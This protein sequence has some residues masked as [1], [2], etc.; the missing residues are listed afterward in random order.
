MTISDSLQAVH[1]EIEQGIGLTK[2]QKC[3]CMREALGNLAALLYEV[4]AEE[5]KA[6]R[7]SI[8]TWKEQ[9]KPV[10]YACLGCVYC[11]PAVAQNTFASAFPNLDQSQGLTCEYRVAPGW[12]SVVGEYFVLDK[13]G[14]VAISTLGSVG[15]AQ[16]LAEAKLKGLAIVGKT[17]TEN[18]G[19][20]K[21]VK[22]IVTNP[23]I[24]YLVVAGKETEGHRSGQTLLALKENGMDA[25][26]R[27][28]SSPG[29]RPILRNVS[30]EEVN[31][32]RKQLTVVDLVGCDDPAEIRARI[33]ALSPKE[34]E[35]CG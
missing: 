35:P 7:E 14:Y 9:L 30:A 13:A 28:T 19:I 27:V 25:T 10:Q 2:C 26:G 5:G 29:K 16:D 15:L 23:G 12:P 4:E 22:N 8:P 18:I 3:G 32:F 17:E 31:A 24:Q 20:D 6:L 21:I 33:E 1:T 11:Y 34:P